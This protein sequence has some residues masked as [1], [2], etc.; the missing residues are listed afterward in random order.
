MRRAVSREE[1]EAPLLPYEEARTR[2]LDAVSALPASTFP[3]LDALSHISA[4]E[5]T[6]EGDVPAFAS[7]AMD[8][9][10]VRAA[11][12]A[13]A[14]AEAPVVLPVRG[15]VPAGHVARAALEPGSA[16]KIMTGAPVPPG[17]DA[18]VPWED[19]EPE[20]GAVRVR[21][22]ATEGR[23]VRPAGEDLERGARVL[24]PGE[25]LT[26]ARLGVLANIGRASVEAR[27]RP[28][29]AI[30]S[31]GDEVVAPGEPLGEGQVY[32][33]NSTIV[34]A[35]CRT[36][37]AEPVASDLLADDPDAIAEWMGR[38]AADADLIV[39]TA[40]ASVGEHDWVRQVI[41]A[42]GAL[43]LW[44]VAIKPGKPLALGRIRGTPVIALPGNPRSAFVTAHAFVLPA[45]RKMAGRDPEPRW[46]TATLTEAVRGG[47]ERL[48]FCGV[49]L[50][51]GH[52]EPLPARSSI[53]L[54]DLAEAD[55]F[56]LVP[57]AGADAG[58]AVRVE[59]FSWG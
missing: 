15:E 20:D 31:T 41:E 9:Y 33:A 57:P 54:G 47:G 10:A 44:K 59:L 19:T 7:S 21:V 35:L 50:R 48:L 24:A 38:A 56:A 1:L 2:I 37:G 25:L 6:A 58:T 30:L 12:T 16:V 34:A 4:E 32:D 46:V 45:L 11:D 13:N 40:G 8:G 5:A 3:L 53:V 28:R 18:V 55:G 43:A 51:G 49:R 22:P 29:V 26:P 52:A 42:E 36:V 27:P 17:A 14:S 23:H 39:S